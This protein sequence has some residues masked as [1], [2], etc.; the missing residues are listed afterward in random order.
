MMIGD[1]GPGTGDKRLE[2]GDQGAGDAMCVDILSLHGGVG[3]GVCWVGN[4]SIGAWMRTGFVANV[5]RGMKREPRRLR[6]FCCAVG[7]TDGESA[8]KGYLSERVHGELKMEGP[9]FHGTDERRRRT[10][11]AAADQ[12][13][14]RGG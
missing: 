5:V 13:D 14:E 1:R 10:D 3:R 7:N 8:G 11:R 6:S 9:D 4:P 2:T 12:E